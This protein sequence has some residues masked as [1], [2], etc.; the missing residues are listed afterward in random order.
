VAIV[1]PS[2]EG[3]RFLDGAGRMRMKTAKA[4]LLLQPGVE[5]YNALE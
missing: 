3:R 1:G 5:I 2:L 4:M